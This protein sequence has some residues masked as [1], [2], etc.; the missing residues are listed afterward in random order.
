MILFFSKVDFYRFSLSWSRLLP[1]GRTDVINT[2]GVDYYNNLIN[3][4]LANGV[5]PMVTLY[6]WDL[7]Q[8][9]QEQG[10][11]LNDTLIVDAFGEYADFAYGA[12]GDRVKFWLTHNEPWVQAVMGYGNGGNAPRVRGSG[13][14]DYIAG[15]NLLKSHAVAWHIYDDKY[16]VTQNGQCAI[17]LDVVWMEPKTQTPEDI[18]AAERSLQFKVI[19]YAFCM[20]LEKYKVSLF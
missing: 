8:P 12:F 3:E 14:S 6:H 20:Y 7:P 9:L 18:E 19:K 16:R 15:L 13:I 1:T 11:W 4:L 17:T 2:A 5:Q 10:G